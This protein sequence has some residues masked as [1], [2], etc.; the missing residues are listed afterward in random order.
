MSRNVFAILLCVLINIAIFGSATFTSAALQPTAKPLPP[1]W[2]P[3]P[4]ITPVPAQTQSTVDTSFPTSSP[5]PTFKP[6][7][8][9]TIQLTAPM[10]YL[11][12]RRSAT[13][14]IARADP[15][16]PDAT[17][18]TQ[19]TENILSFDIAADGRLA[20]TTESGQVLAAGRAK[21]WKSA[22]KTIDPLRAYDAVWSPD[23]KILAFGLRASDKDYAKFARTPPTGVYLWAEKG[24]PKQ[25]IIDTPIT[26]ERITY[27]PV[28]WSPDGKWL[29]IRFTEPSGYGWE[30]FNLAT[31][32]QTR[33][34]RFT[35]NDP[36][37]YGSAMWLPDSSQIL[38]FNQKGNNPDDAG[39][40]ALV[41]LNSAQK[42]ISFVGKNAPKVTSEYHFLPD[43]RL[44]VIGSTSRTEPLQVYVG[45]FDGSQASVKPIGD[46]FR[47]KWPGILLTS[48]TGFPVYVLDIQYGVIVYNSSKTLAYDPAQIGLSAT[49][50]GVYD[51]AVTPPA[52]R[53]GPDNVI[54]PDAA[55]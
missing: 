7:A 35:A 37:Q 19:T 44:V 6:I 23:G 8:L 43:G 4:S 41:D 31:S 30:V 48:P 36:V 46:A 27:T 17:R 20:Y 40:A 32:K 47:L 16:S 9:E 42:P 15:H 14:Y 28:S 51:S 1:T 5:I 29:L 54:L 3:E 13:V 12:N 18:V 53:F 52:W 39:G 26:Q 10:Y 22:A 50:S 2:T 33:L 24:D 55:K 25:I 21:A 49:D 38:L 45:T 34:A 11:S